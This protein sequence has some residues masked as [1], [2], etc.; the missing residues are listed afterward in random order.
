M[1]NDISQDKNALIKQ[2]IR[3]ASLHNNLRNTC[4]VDSWQFEAR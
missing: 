1:K 2:D 4:I 3:Y